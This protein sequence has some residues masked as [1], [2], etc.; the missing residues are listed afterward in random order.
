V[1]TVSSTSVPEAGPLEG[2]RTCSKAG[3]ALGAGVAAKFRR[4]QEE[5]PPPG[6]VAALVSHF[7]RGCRPAIATCQPSHSESSGAER[8]GD[9]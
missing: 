9:P 3:I 4:A 5:D 6:A 8:V 1:I 7:R 2:P